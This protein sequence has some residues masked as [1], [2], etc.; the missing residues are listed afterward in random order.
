MATLLVPPDTTKIDK[1]DV[2]PDATETFS[3][4]TSTSV[5]IAEYQRPFRWRLNT[6]LTELRSARNQIQESS[7][8]TSSDMTSSTT[9]YFVPGIGS[10]SGKAVRWVGS[11]ILSSIS[12]IEIRRRRWLIQ[13]LIT[14]IERLPTPERAKVMLENQTQLKRA[15]DDLVELSS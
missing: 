9:S 11:Q 2:T 12:S 3:L 6:N 8:A 4:L 10:V 15:I 7:R 13:K 14:K 1:S 5:T